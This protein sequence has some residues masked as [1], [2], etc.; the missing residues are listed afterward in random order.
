MN[1]EGHRRSG[2][3][4]IIAIFYTSE[5]QLWALGGAEIVLAGLFA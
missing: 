5:L 1:R 2:A 4:L 3:V